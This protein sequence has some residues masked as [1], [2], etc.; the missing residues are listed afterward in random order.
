MA[1]LD[2]RVKIYRNGQWTTPDVPKRYTG[3]SWQDLQSMKAYFN[4]QWNELIQSTPTIQPF[5]PSYACGYSY[6]EA[7]PVQNYGYT[8]EIDGS[9]TI[10]QIYGTTRDIYGYASLIWQGSW[11]ELYKAHRSGFIFNID[12]DNPVT[13]K[14]VGG[15]CGVVGYKNGSIVTKYFA[16]YEEGDAYYYDADL[17]ADD[18]EITYTYATYDKLLICPINSAN[19]SILNKQILLPIRFAGKFKLDGSGSPVTTNQY[20]TLQSFRWFEMAHNT[21]ETYEAFYDRIMA[22]NGANL[23]IITR[24]T[25]RYKIEAEGQYYNSWTPSN[26]QAGDNS[27]T[28]DTYMA[29]GS[30]TNSYTRLTGFELF[31]PMDTTNRQLNFR[32]VDTV[33]NIVIPN[34]MLF[35]IILF[36]F[37]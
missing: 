29:S 3:G 15:D 11:P 17:I 37:G 31:T 21:P 27:Y 9:I 28:A 24:D 22:T 20:T 2:P 32:V 19:I 4:G 35:G 36:P 23:C 18:N 25:S 1:T 26:L 14:A 16:Y 5:Y 12:P 33:N 7:K 13:V 6:Q 10:D 34:S 8:E 30:L